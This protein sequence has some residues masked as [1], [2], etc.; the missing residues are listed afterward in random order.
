MKLIAASL[1]AASVLGTTTVIAGADRVG[2]FVNP[3]LKK[4]QIPGCALL[5]RHNRKVVLATGYGI[6]NLEHGVPVKSQT[7][8]QSGSIN[9]QFTAMA[10]MVLVQERKLALDDPIS[11]YL[12]VP[13]S[14]SGITVRH[15][16][17]HT[18]GLGDYPENFSLQRDYTEDELLKMVATQPLGFAPGE[19][20]RYSNLGYVTLGILIGKASSE[21]WGD[22]LRKRVFDQLDMKHARVISEADVIPNRAAGYVLND[23]VLK[24]QKWVSPSVNA[25]ADGSLYFTIEDLA[26]W[27]EALEAQK[28]LSRANYEQMWT[29]VRLNDGTTAPYGFGWRI[30]K[31]DSG[32]R[33]IEHGGNWQ[34]FASYIV[35]YPDDRL[36]VAALCNRSGA[37]AGYIAKRIAGFYVPALAQR[38]HTAVKLDPAT[39]SS[40]AGDYRLEDRFTIK[41]SVADSRLETTWLGEKTVLI[42]ESETVFFEEDSDRTF[43]FVKDGKG[44]VTSLV[45]SVPEELTLHKLP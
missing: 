42:P 33:M 4:K 44:K 9:K 20:W 24:N 39:L 26:K 22:F 5:V 11:K 19:K 41:V 16:L 27:D 45:V 35:R 25:T 30:A 36:T 23:H 38:L 14:W 43:R 6:A 2:D 3:Y 29:P 10:V 17:T 21:F 37:S 31:A 15:L 7:V 12:A 1:L 40:C 8:F 13:A 18:S 32:H 28:L 34:G